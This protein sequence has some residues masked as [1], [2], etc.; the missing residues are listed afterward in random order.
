MSLSGTR[1]R[2]HLQYPRKNQ[3][4]VKAAVDKAAVVVEEV[5]M[6]VVVVVE[7]MAKEVVATV[8]VEAMVK[9]EDM[10]GGLE[11]LLEAAHLEA[12]NSAEPDLAKEDLMAVDLAKVDLAKVDLA[13]VDLAEVEIWMQQSYRVLLNNCR[14]HY[15][16]THT[17]QMRTLSHYNLALRNRYSSSTFHYSKYHCWNNFRDTSLAHICQKSTMGILCCLT[18]ILC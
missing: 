17:F 14:Y 4:E 3:V 5:V 8:G 16:D 7:E 18:K 10:G 11:L 2:S 15:L 12:V 9:E 6:E 1:L 13:E